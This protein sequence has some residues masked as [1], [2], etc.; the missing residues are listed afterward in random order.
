MDTLTTK[1][2]MTCNENID[3]RLIYEYLYYSNQASIFV[4]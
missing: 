1:K 3:V 2:F 4:N